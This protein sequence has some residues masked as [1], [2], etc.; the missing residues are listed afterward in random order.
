M[1][2]RDAKIFNKTAVF[3]A[4]IKQ[5]GGNWPHK[6]QWSIWTKVSN[7]VLVG[8]CVDGLSLEK[9]FRFQKSKWCFPFF[10]T[11]K[12]CL[13]PVKCDSVII[14]SE[15]RLMQGL[16]YACRWECAH[17][18]LC[19]IWANVLSSGKEGTQEEVPRPFSEC[20]KS[21]PL[22]RFMWRLPQSQCVSHPLCFG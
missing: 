18:A 4:P 5:V 12:M 3:D 17:V 8:H 16:H 2:L 14:K 11:F 9:I 7:L 15:M 19:F 6:K 10:P 20:V 22:V 21:R 13:R 1:Y